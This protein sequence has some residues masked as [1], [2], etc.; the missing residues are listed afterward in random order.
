MPSMESFTGS[1]KQAAS[2]CS[3]RPVAKSILNGADGV[4]GRYPLGAN[5]IPADGTPGAPLGEWMRGLHELNVRTTY[6]DQS[7]S[8]SKR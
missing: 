3:G 4:L 2:C 6:H 7:R 5:W 8:T 1:T